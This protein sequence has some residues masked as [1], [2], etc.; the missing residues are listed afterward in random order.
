MI[1]I[2]LIS[3][4]LI[5][6]LVTCWAIFHVKKRKKNKVKK[7]KTEVKSELKEEKKDEKVEIKED[8][9][10]TKNSKIKIVKSA[11]LQPKIERVY[12]K[13]EILEPEDE[14][15]AVIRSK[16]VKPKKV[17]GGAAARS[18]ERVFSGKNEEVETDTPKV[19]EVKDSMPNRT[20]SIADRIEFRE[21]LAQIYGGFG[22][23]VNVSTNKASEIDQIQTE[24]MESE[25]SAT[26]FSDIR[27]SSMF[28]GL[29]GEP[30][31]KKRSKVD[32]KKITAKDMVLA[33]TIM[34][35][36]KLSKNLKNF[37]KK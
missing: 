15:V 35:R 12:A 19:E 32:L 1:E 33:Q 37:N 20:P 8:I 5:G 27:S 18:I 31:P 21:H 26:K 4:L 16:D 3:A 6:C 2:L 36:P 29:F 10:L 25:E 23:G 14:S 13:E 30:E 7:A 11:T 22:T 24:E 17:L 34:N 9:Q 28:A